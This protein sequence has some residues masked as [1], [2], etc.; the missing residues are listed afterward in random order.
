MT[1]IDPRAVVSPSAKLGKNVRVGPYAVVGDDV[2]ISDDCVVEHH[3]VV[4]GPSSFGRANRF[5]SFSIVGGD[6]QDYT[7]TGQ[8]VRLEV[9]D[10]NTFRE[11]STVHRGTIKGGGSTRVGNH[12][13]IMAYAHVGHD[14]VIG[15][16]CTIINGA[17]FAGHTHIDD[18]A[19][20]S[21]FVLVHQFSRIGCHSYIGAGTII[22]QDVPPFSLVVG[23]RENRCYGINKVG[24]ERRG[25]SA[26]RIHSIEKAYRYLLRSK[27]NTSQAVEK[28]RGTLSDSDDV[29]TL[30]SF[31]ESA[32]DRGLTK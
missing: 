10:D 27:L 28:M 18:Y 12:N 1:E 30:I 16:H 22:T 25:F 8:P 9:G 4:Q 13:L 5:C 6:P 26:E 2:E 31:I 11:F 3:A 29:L 20:V 21:S 7:Y 24:L 14:C 32:S 15:N 17:Q 19:T 23:S